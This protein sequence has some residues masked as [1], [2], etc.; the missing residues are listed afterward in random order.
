M[1]GDV[2]PIFFVEILHPEI[3]H[4][5]MKKQNTPQRSFYNNKYPPINEEN[6]TMQDI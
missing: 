6:L 5:V 3:A 2:S 4:I 1:G